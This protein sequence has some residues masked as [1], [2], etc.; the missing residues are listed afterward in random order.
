MFADTTSSTRTMPSGLPAC[1]DNALAHSRKLQSLIRDAIASAGGWISFARYMEYALYHPGLGYYNGGATKLGGS[2]DFVTAP[3][4]SSLFGY[5]LAAQ[6]RQIFECVNKKTGAA[7]ILELG[8]GS[9]KLAVDLLQELE[10][11]NC[12]PRHY[13]ILEVSA[14]LRERQQH[15]LAEKMPYLQSRISWLDRLPDQFC[16]TILANE[17][18]DALP[19]HLVKWQGHE[20]YERGVAW[21]NHEQ[22]NEFVWVDQPVDN[23]ALKTAATALSGLINPE[24]HNDITYISEINLNAGFLVQT[25]AK[26]L[27]V[28][29]AVLIDYGFGRGEYYHPQRDQGTLMCHYRHHAHGDPFFLP[30]LQDITSHVDFSA[31]TE[32][33]VETDMTLLGY[34]TQ[35]HFLLNCG[36]TEILARTPAEDVHNYLPLANQLQKL[37]SPA[38]MGELFKVIAFGKQITEPLIGFS[39]GDRT[40]ML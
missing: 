24:L 4:I 1:D 19:V 37:V 16:G 25:L 39:G 8:A 18:F 22:A 13:Y 34:T 32:A 40:R 33:A 38:E 12:L 3:E 17:V 36:V 5:A 35:A 10:R 20:I 28:G 11:Q 29:A 27:H 6:V 7:D 31:V 15:L 2:G 9:G 14:E 21:N 23:N 30:G 26:I